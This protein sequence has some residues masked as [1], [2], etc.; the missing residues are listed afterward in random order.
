MRYI[1]PDLAL[2]RS[3]Q[4]E[5]SAGA[6]I[7]L[8]VYCSSQMLLREF[9]WF[10]LRLLTWLI[11]AISKRRE[12]ALDFGG[13]S[14]VFLST[15]ASGFERVSLID[16]NVQQATELKAA[17]QLESVELHSQNI[18]EFD[19]PTESFD[20]IV[21]ADVLEHFLDH[22]LPLSKIRAWLRDDGTLFTSLPTENVWYRALRVV[23]RK[24]KPADH[25]HSARDVENALRHAGFRKRF[26]LYHPLVLPLFPLFRISAWQKRH[27]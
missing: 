24:E 5:S 4:G 20:A 17:L 1:R 8:D 3:I 16:L 10:R 15:L 7:A 18:A 14:G 11:R 13:G 6:D 21:A 12:H 22:D 9:F 25:Y 2:M 19:F 23:F 26:G 27:N